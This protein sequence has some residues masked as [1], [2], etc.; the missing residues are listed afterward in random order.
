MD[1]KFISEKVTQTLSKPHN[2]A[3]IPWYKW[4]K[5]LANEK[6]AR[7]ILLVIARVLF[8]SK[9]SI[10]TSFELFIDWKLYKTRGNLLLSNGYV[11]AYCTAS[12]YLP[13]DGLLHTQTYKLLFQ[14]VPSY[15]I[16]LA[17]SFLFQ[18]VY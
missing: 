3:Q 13:F 8:F 4:R 6:G 9:N 12:I 15:Q 18:S 2:F 7:S 14:P 10:R 5:V 1:N 16:A 11:Y 17:F